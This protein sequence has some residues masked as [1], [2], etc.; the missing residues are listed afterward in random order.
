VSFSVIPEIL[1]VFGNKYFSAVQNVPQEWKLLSL[2]RE[3]CFLLVE[4]NDLGF[5]AVKFASLKRLTFCE[6]H[7][8]SQEQT[9]QR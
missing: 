9:N 4:N 2:S 3:L 8:T 7:T 5:S 1:L 6:S